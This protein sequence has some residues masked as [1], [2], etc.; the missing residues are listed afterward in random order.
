MQAFRR[1]FLVALL[2]GA[3]TGGLSHLAHQVGT[4]PVILAAETFES[5]PAPAHAHDHAAATPAHSHDA[6]AWA[7]EDGAERTLYTLLADVLTGIA[8]ALI[9]TA[10]FALR[11]GPVGWRQGLFWGLAG[12]ATFTLAPG[13]GLPPELPGTEAAPLL[14]RQGWWAATA[15]LTGGGLAVLAFARHAGWALLAV[16]MIALPHLVGAPQPLEHAAAAPED[17]TRRFVVAVTVTS[18]LFWAVLGGSAGWLY[19]R[20]Q[21]A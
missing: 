10:A 8:Y 12:F 17:L 5:T 21:R 6:E 2:A 13:L 7:P 9:L 15:L 11:G 4:V 14:A 16:A 3:L 19:A 18:F 20:F 1:L